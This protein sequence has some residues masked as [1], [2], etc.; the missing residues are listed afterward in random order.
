M[1]EIVLHQYPFSPFAEVAKLALGLKGLS[2]KV[3]T[4]PNVAPKPELTALTGGYERIPVLQIGADIYCDTAAI[5][6]ALEAHKPEPSLYPAPLGA[7]GRMIALWSANC[8]FMP[9]VGVALGTDPNV[10]PPAFWEDRKARFGMDPE[11]FLPMV[12]HLGGQ[13]G[14]GAELLS[15]ALSDGRQFIGGE[16]PGHADLAL[17]MNIRFVSFAGKAPA[18]FGPAIADWYARV[19]AIGYGDQVDWT[20]DQAIEHAAAETPCPDSAVADGH[21]FAAGDEVHV[22][23]EAPEKATVAGTLVGLDDR[24]ISIARDDERAGRVHVHFPRLG[25]VLTKA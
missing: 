6:D 10:V 8:W 19:E 21:G 13:F 23:V 1:A 24:R 9:A 2:S 5:I 17:Y 22:K 18:D 16:A 3:V 7:A 4:Q 14:G 15:E 25:Q 20:T 12:P 11:T